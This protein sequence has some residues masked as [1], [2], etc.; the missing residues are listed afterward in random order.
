[1]H[2]FLDTS[3]LIKLFHEEPGSAL[4]NALMDQPNRKAIVSRLA[5][6]EF[7]SVVAQKVR[8][9]DL[10]P[11][12]AD[13]LID[14]LFASI[15]SGEFLVESIGDDVFDQ[16]L[17]LINQHGRKKSLKILDALHLACALGI[18]R[19][20]PLDAFVTGDRALANAAQTAGLRVLFSD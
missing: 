8:T 16:A 9:G 17:R 7:G 10:T 14:Q 12:D 3:A 6:V 15:E 13:L 2:F 4:V 19:L 18:S 11:E 1:M 5:L 20:S